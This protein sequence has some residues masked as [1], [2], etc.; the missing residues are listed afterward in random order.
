MDLH[1]NGKRAV[2]T[3]ASDG[4]GL[5]ISRALAAEGVRV[6]GAARR[7]TM[8]HVEGVDYLALDLSSADAPETLVREAVARLGG[9]DILVNN[10]GAGHLRGGFTSVT[11]DDWDRV[12]NL[13][14]MTAIRAMRAA[15][16]HL[17]A[18]DGGVIINIASV[19]AAVPRVEVPDYS[20]TKAGLLSIGKAVASEY[21]RQGVRVV[22]V[23]PAAVATPFW[24][25]P[26]GVAAQIEA[27]TGTPAADVL[28]TIAEANPL[29][30][31]LEP[32]EVADAVVFLASPRASAITGT[33]VKVDG[34]FVQ[35]M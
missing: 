32:I 22:T 6:L 25:G 17:V 23:S 7:T 13:N 3:G 30:R 4:I 8:P 11:D 35:T 20:T 15:L 18:D 27:A 31:L 10:V 34:G 16:P 33:D 28:K 19:N 24:L 14:L 26:D 21:A 5:A 12:V 29:G 2:V 9:L 1:L